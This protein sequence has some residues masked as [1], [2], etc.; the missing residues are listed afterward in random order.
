MNNFEMICTGVTR[1]NQT[2]TD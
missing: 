2:L 1:T